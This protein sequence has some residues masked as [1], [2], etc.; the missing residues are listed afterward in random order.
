M[1]FKR[2]ASLLL[3]LLLPAVPAVAEVFEGKTAAL[4]TTAIVAE[5]SGVLEETCVRVGQRVSAGDA[6]AELRATKGFSS[7]DGTVTLTYAR[8]GDSVSGTLLEVMPVERYTVYCTVEKAYQSA[9]TTLVHVGETV[10]IKCTTDGTHRAIGVITLID[11]GEYRVLTVGG[12][13]YVGETVYLYRDEAFTSA[14]RVGIGTVVVSDTQAYEA[15]GEVTR[16]LVAEGD[17]VERGQLLYEL[18]GGTLRAGVDGI[19]TSLSVQ[20]GDQVAE[21]QVVGAL[22]ADSDICV[23]VQVDEATASRLRVGDAATMSFAGDI[24]DAA[25]AGTVVEISGIARSGLFAVRIRPASR[26]GLALGMSVA[27]RL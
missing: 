27:V 24:D 23:E 13:L 18:G 1:M 19:V 7:Q 25:V 21:G 4:A 12:E 10:Y 6:L 17:A 11:G 20:P 14:Q 16:L 26:E 5:A 8:E 9:E 2:L 15:Q 3:A 22:V